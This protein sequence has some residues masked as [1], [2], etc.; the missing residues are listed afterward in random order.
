MSSSSPEEAS[1]PSAFTVNMEEITPLRPQHQHRNA[2]R[3]VDGVLM[4]ALYPLFSAAA[5]RSL[6]PRWPRRLPATLSFFFPSPAFLLSGR[7]CARLQPNACAPPPECLRMVPRLAPIQVPLFRFSSVPCRR[8]QLLGQDVAAPFPGLRS[9]GSAPTSASASFWAAYNAR[10]SAIRSAMRSVGKPCCRLPKK[11]PGPRV[12]RSNF[13]ISKPSFVWH[14]TKPLFTASVAWSLMSTQVRFAFAASHAPA[15]LVQCRKAIPLGVFDHDGIGVG[16][17]HAHLDDR[18]GHQHVQR[19]G[20][21]GVHHGG[22]F[23]GLQP[24]MHQSH[25]VMLQKGWATSV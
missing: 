21:K 23:R 18:G 10:L 14:K 13:A 11:S 7:H 20:L 2:K 4:A 5:Q 17:V 8:E 15:Q 3:L 12:S 25:A 9:A 24:P 16:H 19:T 6:P 1:V 22:L